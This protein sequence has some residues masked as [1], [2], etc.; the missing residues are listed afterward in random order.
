MTLLLWLAS[1][2][3][4]GAGAGADDAYLACYREVLAAPPY[5]EASA[6]ELESARLQIAGAVIDHCGRLVDARRR[7][8]EHLV[9]E[10][11]RVGRQM[12]E[13]RLP[14]GL[15]A[16][17]TEMRLTAAVGQDLDRAEPRMAQLAARR[18]RAETLA[19]VA[20]EGDSEAEAG[21][22]A[23]LASDE[24]IPWLDALQIYNSCLDR[25]T[26]RRSQQDMPAETVLATALNDC[27]AVR[28]RLA[29]DDADPMTVA[30][31]SSEEDLRRD[32]TPAWVA[33]LR[34]LAATP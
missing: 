15:A 3:A 9:R 6:E 21:D 2:A 4:S 5:A 14:R 24:Q 34:A 22:A 25:A 29:P 16:G 30:L 28:D 26:V 27:R 18:L 31:L 17:L 33:E 11:E 23:R 7:E 12:G 1:A 13:G 8:A 32:R 20:V 19:L 10:A